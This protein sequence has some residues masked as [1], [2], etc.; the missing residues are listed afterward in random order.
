MW[1]RAYKKTDLAPLAAS[2]LALQAGGV[3]KSCQALG[4]ELHPL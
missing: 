3:E 1:G 2:G 4:L